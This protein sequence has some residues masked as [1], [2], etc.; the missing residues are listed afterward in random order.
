MYCIS[1]RTFVRVAL[2]RNTAC[3]VTV[4]HMDRASRSG[5]C[6]PTPTAVVNKQGERE[7]LCVGRVRLSAHL[8]F[9]TRGTTEISNKFIYKQAL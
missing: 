7:V 5:R 8:N 3:S 1:Q 6:W 2:C 9:T 4:I